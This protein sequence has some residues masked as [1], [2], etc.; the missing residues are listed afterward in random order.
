MQNNYNSEIQ[1]MIDFWAEIGLTP[2]Y[3]LNTDGRFNGNLIEFKLVFTDLKKHKEQ[4]KRYIKAYNSA[5]LPIPRYSFLISINER[6][7]IKIDNERNIEISHGEWKEPEDFLYD[8]VNCKDYV[9]G[10]IDE[11]SIV[12]YN[13]KLCKDFPKI[14][15]TKEDVKNEFIF[16]CFL[17]IK[18]FDWNGQIKA[19]EQNKMQIGW[20]HFNMNMLGPN[21]LKKQLGAFF[22]PD[23]YVE[24]STAMVRD[25]IRRV[26]QRNDYIIL[27][28]CA[29]TGNLE[30]FLHE[31]ELLHC[32]LNTYDYTEW[33]TLKGLYEGRVKMI[34]PPTRKHL[35]FNNGLLT[36]GDALSEEFGNFCFHSGQVGFYDSEFEKESKQI[37]F[38]LKDPKMT[39]IMLENPPFV[40]PQG[41]A[42]KGKP[43]FAVKD[44]Y[45]YKVMAKEKFDSKNVNREIANLFIW[46][47]FKYYLKENDFYILYSPIKYWKSQHIVDYKYI[48]GYICNRKSFNASDGGICLIEWQKIKQTNDTLVFNS[49]IGQRVIKKLYNNPL[50]LMQ[51][52][53]RKPLA[54]I[55]NLSNIPKFENGKLINDIESMISY[56]KVQK[57]YKLAED[58]ILQQLPLFVA[59]SYEMEDYT[60]IEVIMKSAD[61]GTKYQ[62]DRE[63]LKNCF[64]WS[65]ISQ[66][67]KCVSND[68][69]RNELCL[70]QNTKADEILSQFTL[71]DKDNELLFAWQNVLKQI[72]LTKEYDNKFSYGL[73][74]IENEINIKEPSG[75][76]N[77]KGEDIMKPKYPELDEK[78]KILKEILKSYY[79]TQ[80]KDKLFEYELLK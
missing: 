18:P 32:V 52:S 16:P 22:T 17:K 64:L 6:K 12:A 44:N 40:E 33:T 29:G 54:W 69:V 47:A 72:I 26:P 11:Y 75:T 28:R 60:E 3:E 34:I 42:D 38:W 4:L 80:I 66:K 21:L 76:K 63:L 2:D 50:P 46:S 24:I 70:M 10:Y 65:C 68:R 62:N 36:N 37:S 9:L 77:K 20:L 5:A 13:N 15:K 48:G 7:F 1:G 23:R 35:D 57:A 27:D 71:N 55:F 43:T 53:N 51:D 56:L 49:D 30:R 45:L 31:E 79:K 74:Q 59:N 67:N 61:G 41:G 73:S 58:N 25:A 14:I 39:I 78:I 19:E 8:L